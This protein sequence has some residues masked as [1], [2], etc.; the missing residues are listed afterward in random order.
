MIGAESDQPLVPATRFSDLM[1][2]WAP[3]LLDTLATRRRVYWPDSG[4]WPVARH[5]AFADRLH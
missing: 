1:R 4:H 5:G 2:E 3:P